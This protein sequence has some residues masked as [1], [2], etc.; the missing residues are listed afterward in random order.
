MPTGYRIAR[1]LVDSQGIDAA[2]TGLANQIREHNPDPSRLALIGIRRG[3]VHL[4]E[5]LAA[6]LAGPGHEVPV[7]VVDI[8]LYRDDLDRV[9]ANPIVGPTQ[10]PFEIEDI[11]VVL[12]DDVLY[13][14]R[15]IRAAL[16]ALL[17]YGRPSCVQ[18]AVL[19]DRGHRQLPIQADYVGQRIDTRRDEHVEVL[20]VEEGGDD[21]VVLL[22][23]HVGA[24]GV[25]HA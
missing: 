7:G 19:V 9:G 12:V 3:G 6:R 17:D 10:I 25:G 16:D 5:R 1:T 8:T 14:G 15:T 11:T 21:S 22:E 24:G 20:L 2:L 4:A 23:R 13:T 18:L